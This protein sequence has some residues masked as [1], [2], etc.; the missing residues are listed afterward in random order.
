MVYM[1][2]EGGQCIAI[3][4]NRDQSTSIQLLL[5]LR[6]SMA[7]CMQHTKYIFGFISHL[8]HVNFFKLLHC[9][10]GTNN[11]NG[12]DAGIPSTIT[13]TANICVYKNYYDI[14]L[15]T[16]SCCCCLLCAGFRK[17]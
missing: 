1:F 5:I 15:M 6:T 16:I 4:Q 12:T 14:I 2:E 13:I 9:L 7:A 3:Q 17:T 10:S 8:Y 11:W